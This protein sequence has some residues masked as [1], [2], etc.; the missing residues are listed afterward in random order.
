MILQYLDFSKVI[1]KYSGFPVLI[2]SGRRFTYSEYFQLV[3][4]AAERLTAAGVDSGERIAILSENRPEILILI[5]ALWV[6]G[7]AA[8]PVSTRFPPN[9]VTSLLY[10]IGVSKIVSADPDQIHIHLKG[11]KNFDL[12]KIGILHEK[13]YPQKRPGLSRKLPFTQEASVILTSGSS[14]RSK[15]VMHT[16]GNHFYNAL[17][18]RQ[19]LPFGK[20]DRWL[21]SLPLYH[22]GGFAILIRAILGGGAVVVPDSG[23]PLQAALEKFHPT[24]ISLVAAQLNR[25]LDNQTAIQHLQNTKAILLGGSAIPQNRIQKAFQLGLPIFVSYGSTEMASQVTATQ[26]GDDLK[27]LLSAGKV[28]PFREIR[29]GAGGEILVKGQTLFKGYIRQNGIEIPFDD[30]GWFH[31]KD[32]GYF[33]ENACLHVTGR[34][35]NRFISG[36]ENIQPE[37]IEHYLSQFPG[38]KQVL[39]VPVPDEAFGERPAAFIKFEKEKIPDAETIRRFLQP[40]ISRFKIP[41]YFFEWPPRIVS[42]GVKPS[43]QTFQKLAVRLIN[44]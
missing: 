7:A 23:M 20:G 35:D 2:T 44:R 26:P 39:V 19:N 1:K 15:G 31:T 14:G 28:L 16:I 40:K 42:Q 27:K 37:E 36:G 33:D 11:F 17:G 30:K 8:V 6:I 12:S 22:V 10:Q 38:V 29:I 32:R 34:L 24:H 5:P 43:R 4:S 13:I 21:L 3:Q 9:Q 25:L 18:S 41:D